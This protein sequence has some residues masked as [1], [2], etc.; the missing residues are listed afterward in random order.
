MLP[1]WVSLSRLQT[2]RPPS[3]AA[4]HSDKRRDGEQESN[5][6]SR[7]QPNWAG[8]ALVCAAY[9]QVLA[10]LKHYEQDRPR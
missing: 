4:R 8:L 7:P 10:L 6:V 9:L 5:L 1:S 2:Y 3:P